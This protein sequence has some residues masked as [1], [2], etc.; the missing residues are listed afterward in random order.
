MTREKTAATE[1]DV[2]RHQIST[3]ADELAALRAAAS[4]T[5]NGDDDQS[6]SN[7]VLLEDALS[8]QRA[9]F[10]KEIERQTK[11]HTD[12]VENLHASIA[13]LTKRLNVA[14]NDKGAIDAQFN[15]VQSKN[16]SLEKSFDNV[17]KEK[18][19][20]E[21]LN[22]QL[23]NQVSETLSFN[24]SLEQSLSDQRQ[25]CDS[26]SSD[27]KLLK[28]K[29]ET[30][31][32]EHSANAD[33]SLKQQRDEL[34]ERDAQIQ[35]FTT[36]LQKL[37]AT[38]AENEAAL[39]SSQKENSDLREKC[40]TLTT[41]LE[42]ASMSTE[43]S[44]A[45]IL[46]EKG[47]IES[48]IKELEGRFNDEKRKLTEEKDNIE[49]L[50]TEQIS[51][52]EREFADKL[53]AMKNGNDVTIS[54][55]LK[56][57]ATLRNNIDEKDELV[58]QLQS[59]LEVQQSQRGSEIERMRAEFESERAKIV[60][61][62]ISK[63]DFEK[64]MN[65]VRANH[66]LE[67]Q[68]VRAQLDKVNETLQKVET[69]VRQQAEEDKQRKLNEAQLEAE[70]ELKNQR[71]KHVDEVDQLRQKMAEHVDKMKAKFKERMDS[72]QDQSSAEIERL[73]GVDKEKDEKVSKL[74]EKLKALSSSASAIKKEN[75]ELKKSIKSERDSQQSLNE[76][77]DALKRDLDQ[78]AQNGAQTATELLQE[79][80]KLQS[81]KKEVEDAANKLRDERDIDK[82]RIEELLGKV[83]ALS[84]NLNSMIDVRRV[85][86]EQLSEARK[87]ETKLKAS[88]GE[89]GNLR[90]QITKLKLD[91]TQITNLANRLQAEK[92]ANERNHG[93]RTALV[94][95]LENQLSEVNDSN[96]EINAKLEAA[97]Y[98]LKH[99]DEMIAS[100]E[101]RIGKL[102]NDLAEAT[103]ATK[104]ANDLLAAAQKGAEVKATKS[105]ESMQKDLQ[106]VK[107]QMA[108]K[109]AAAQKIIQ[110]KE[111]ECAELRKIN[112]ALQLEVDK[113]SLS[114][115]RIFE[116]A[117]KQSN[118]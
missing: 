11:Q 5:I 72:Y 46:A 76:K 9:S 35:N 13:D 45:S 115:R 8:Q 75:D 114:D 67:L 97:L 60:L 26:L 100:S 105:T 39:T 102:E 7:K 61:D 90:N 85:Q 48:K 10:E 108:R 80:E 94:G 96:A 24:K 88:E 98:D 37:K 44:H 12:D 64:Q 1:N 53:D 63:V 4:A 42:S 58:N 81:E 27:L 95:M 30:M 117:A 25:N 28:E 106:I 83:K 77:I 56:Q 50:H 47:D 43:D 79:Q 116:L 65:D 89:V 71:Q 113:G 20:M 23:Q 99:R 84:E 49:R 54:D 57:I 31:E 69:S 93:Q 86:D 40:T 112:N 14:S 59:S 109:S 51:Q 21:E 68:E 29:L 6:D 36:Q 41:Q 78:T 87:T 62:S 110:E 3:T 18:T 73:K 82:Q 92:D 55:A 104:R 101:D 17:N 34:S 16:L 38:I 118:P 33:S 74:L 91:L 111:H 107:Q 52:L 32:L 103:T 2:L 19:E 70:T 66:E 22:K 15:E